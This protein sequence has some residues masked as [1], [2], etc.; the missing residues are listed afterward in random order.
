MSLQKY[1]G[2]LLAGLGIV[3]VLFYTTFVTART[4]YN[5][6]ATLLIIILGGFIAVGGLLAARYRNFGSSIFFL[7]PLMSKMRGVFPVLFLFTILA[8]AADV[9]L[10]LYAV[11]HF[12]FGVEANHVVASLIRN[13]DLPAWLGQQFA[14]A[15]ITGMLFG[16]FRNIYLRTMAAFFTL[17][18]LGYAVAT[19]VND[20]LV[21]YSLSILRV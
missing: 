14:P 11:S 15:L 13:G 12:G 6:S 2:F 5:P 7:N 4:Y 3:L 17:G 18:T 19:V 9:I 8:L 20:V 21:V 16:V 10:T 1:R